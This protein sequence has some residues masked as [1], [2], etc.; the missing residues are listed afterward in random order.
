[1]EASHPELLTLWASRWVDL[2]DFE[3]VR[4]VTSSEFWAKTSESDWR[5]DCAP[6]MFLPEQQQC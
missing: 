4:V 3:I 6:V 1:M 5:E 2:V